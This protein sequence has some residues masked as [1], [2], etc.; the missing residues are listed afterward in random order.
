M[1]TTELKKEKRQLVTLEVTTDPTGEKFLLT[2]TAAPAF[3]TILQQ[4][5]VDTP[6]DDKLSFSGFGLY[7]TRS[8][9]KAIV[10]RELRSYGLLLFTDKLLT[11]GSVT[12]ILPSASGAETLVADLRNYVQRIVKVSQVL[13]K[14]TIEAIH[15]ATTKTE[16][17]Q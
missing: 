10:T 13:G 15:T 12:V 5:V 17:S 16:V 6:Q 4:F 7:L 8:K 14:T 2:I 11:E 9:V 3:K 1:T